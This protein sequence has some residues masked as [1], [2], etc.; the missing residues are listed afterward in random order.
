MEKLLR[1]APRA[2]GSDLERIAVA[3]KAQIAWN[4]PS[5]RRDPRRFS[6]LPVDVTFVRANRSD[7]LPGRCFNVSARGFGASLAGELRDGEVVSIELNFPTE[8]QTWLA[9]AIVRHRQ[10]LDHGFEFSDL[11]ISRQKSLLRWLRSDEVEPEI[12]GLHPREAETVTDGR[13]A[14][15]RWLYRIGLGLV[16]VLAFG[17]G[18]TWRWHAGWREI[19][20]RLP[21]RPHTIENVIAEARVPGEE[22]AKRLTH[23]VEP[24]YPEAARSQN[25]EGSVV[26]LIV[27]GR[28]GSVVDVNALS[29]PEILG[30]AAAE[31]VRWWQFQPFQIN[32]KPAVVS[33]TVEIDFKP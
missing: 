7:R 26:L 16:L 19:E 3:T 18:V 23:R 9:D 11:S 8:K 29:G 4:K 15:G 27:V 14:S 25:L 12:P 20:S 6:A 17:A 2:E 28:D 30:R 24:D 33:T 5:R 1:F 13:E 32:G 10:Q 22:M 21:T 31:A